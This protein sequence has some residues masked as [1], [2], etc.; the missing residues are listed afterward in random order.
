MTER[1][2]VVAFLRKAEQSLAGAESEL[3]AGRYDSCANR[4]YYACFQAAI[5]ALTGIGVGPS[6]RDQRWRHDAIQA[7]FVEQLINRRKHY[8]P[9]FR[10]TFERLV[11]LRHTADYRPDLVNAAQA[12]RALRRAREF[13]ESV[14]GRQGRTG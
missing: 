6:P 5:A 9:V 1:I 14:Q 11:R 13:V 10:D 12:D 8:S 3:A 2:D 7:Q 4:A